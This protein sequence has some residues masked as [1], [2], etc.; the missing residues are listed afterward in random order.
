MMNFFGLYTNFTAHEGMV[1]VAISTVVASA[2]QDIAKI[3][4]PGNDQV[5]L[6]PSARSR[7]LPRNFMLGFTFEEGV[8][9]AKLVVG[10]EF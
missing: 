2:G 10:S 1:S 9:D 8:S 3:S 4:T 6:V 7:V 5:E